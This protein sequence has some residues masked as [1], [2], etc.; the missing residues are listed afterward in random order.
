MEGTWIMISHRVI[1]GRSSRRCSSS[2]PSLA[3]HTYSSSQE[4]KS[5]SP[6]SVLESVTYLTNI[7]WCTWHSGAKLK[8]LQFT[9]ASWKAD[10]WNS[11]NIFWEAEATKGSIS[12]KE[13]IWL[14]V[15]SH[16]QLLV[17][18]WD[19]LEI[20]PSSDSCL[21]LLLTVPAW[22]ILNKCCQGE[23]VNRKLWKI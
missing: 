18:E 7:I 20:E 8:A 17:M 1:G 16:N 23:P 4:V 21:S 22:N 11:T 13:P 6:N 2:V 5:L 3:I 14:L 10:S 9:W 12:T 19:I 15:E